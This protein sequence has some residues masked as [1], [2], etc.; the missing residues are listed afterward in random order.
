MNEVVASRARGVIRVRVVAP[1]EEGKANKAV[2]AILRQRLG[3]GA[4]SLRL[5]GGASSRQKWIEAD[6]LEEIELWRRLEGNP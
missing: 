6:G 5:V 2:L 3:I 1:P 4:G